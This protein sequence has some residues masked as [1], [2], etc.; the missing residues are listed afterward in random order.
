M[1]RDDEKASIIFGLINMSPLP[2]HLC[3][4]LGFHRITRNKQG[5]RGTLTILSELQTRQGPDKATIH[6]NHYTMMI[7]QGKS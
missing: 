3:L 2:I 4:G 1:Q 5:T 7:D 6:S